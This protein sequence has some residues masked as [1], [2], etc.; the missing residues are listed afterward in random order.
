ML[1][2]YHLCFKKNT[3]FSLKDLQ[4]LSLQNSN[5]IYHAAPPLLY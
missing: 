2:A 5:N 4:K 1:S 3:L